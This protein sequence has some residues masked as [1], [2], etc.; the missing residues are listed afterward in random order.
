VRIIRLRP[1]HK[2]STI[3]LVP[4]QEEIEEDIENE[5]TFVQESLH[6]AEPKKVIEAAELAP[7]EVEE[8]AEEKI[9]TD[10]LFDEE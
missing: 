10:S 1:D 4:K 8:V 7:D 9:T 3:A 2:V 6:V 5:N